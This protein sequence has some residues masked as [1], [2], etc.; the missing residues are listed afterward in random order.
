[1]MTEP[2]TQPSRS[3]PPS[4]ATLKSLTVQLKRL[5]DRNKLTVRNAG[6]NL[7]DGLFRGLGFAL[8]ATLLFGIGLGLLSRL[9]SVPLVGK[10]VVEVLRI[11]ES[12]R[13]RPPGGKAP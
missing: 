9:V 13:G 3:G 11:V 6:L 5:N 8:G 7:L 2:T 10:Y 4:S 12:E 1:M